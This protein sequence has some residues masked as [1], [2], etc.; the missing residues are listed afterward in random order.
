[1]ARLTF[2]SLVLGV[3]ALVWRSRNSVGGRASKRIIVLGFAVLVIFTILFP[4]ITTVVAGWIGI[5]RGSDLVFY[6]TSFAVMF[7]A[8]LVYLE[9][10]R[11]DSR[12][13]QLTR[14]LALSEWEAQR[15]DLPPARPGE[16][17]SDGL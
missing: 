13:A 6:L 11:M 10:R 17:R 16:D 15:Q 2:I 5:G 4:Q 3:I 9:F 7:L 8:A 12:I 1:M 14:D